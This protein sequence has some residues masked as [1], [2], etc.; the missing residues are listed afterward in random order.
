MT[1]SLLRP[2]GVG[3]PRSP[4]LDADDQATH[5]ASTDAEA[6]W[7]LRAM[8][9]LRTPGPFAFCES[10]HSDRRTGST[11]ITGISLLS[12]DAASPAIQMSICVIVRAK[13]IPAFGFVISALAVGVPYF[14]IPYR[15]LNLPTALHGPGL[16][17]LV[18]TA[19]LTL[20]FAATTFW[21]GVAIIGASVPAI[22]LLRVAVETLAD[23][24]SHNLWPLEIIIGS[25]VSAPC[26]FVGA[27]LGWAISKL[28]SRD[29]A[30]AQ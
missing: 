14:L 24:T 2:D 19:A 28:R 27:L 21:K 10:V 20:G 29:S 26:A 7:T 25:V 6:F 22:I 8:C 30:I 16:L 12:L 13:W 17:V 11:Y 4:N 23:P 3:Q 5:V 18:A 15:E 1:K 9:F